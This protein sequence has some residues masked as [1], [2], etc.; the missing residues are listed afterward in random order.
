M[1]KYLSLLFFSFCPLVILSFSQEKNLQS[2]HQEAEQA[3]KDKEYEK[4]KKAYEKLLKEVR[5]FSSLQSDKYPIDWT[6]Y[7][8]CILR[9]SYIYQVEEDYEKWESMI[10][11]LIEKGPPKHQLAQLK[12]SLARLKCVQNDPQT[13]FILM[14]EALLLLPSKEWSKEN[15]SF[16]LGLTSMLDS[17]Y[18]SLVKQGE[19]YFASGLIDLAL[20]LYRE[21]LDGIERG[22][23][24]KSTPIL[25]KQLKYRVAEGN[26]LQADYDQTLSIIEKLRSE[27]QTDSID[28]EALYLRALVYRERQEFEKATLA[29]TEYLNG[30][31]K[32]LHYREALLELGLLSYREQNFTKAKKYL[33]LVAAGADSIE[34]KEVIVSSLYLARIYLKEKQY[35][36]ADR[37]LSTLLNTLP[38]GHSLIYEI[39]YLIGLVL[40]EGSEYLDA[41]T[42]FEL[43]LP[44]K[45]LD[46]EGYVAPWTPDALYQLGWCYLKLADDPLKGVSVQGA[47]ISKAESLFEILKE[48]SKKEE[49]HLACAKLFLLKISYLADQKA[50]EDLVALLTPHLKTFTQDGQVQALLLLAEGADTYSEKEIFYGQATQDTY[51]TSSNYADA[52]YQRGL[53]H[54]QE[55]L[56]VK[57]SSYFKEAAI[58][59]EKSFFLFEA[60]NCSMA[61]QILKLEAEA[62]YFLDTRESRFDSLSILEKLLH[63]YNQLYLSLEDQAHTLYLRGLVASKITTLDH[64][65]D[66]LSLAEESLKGVISFFPE[67]EYAE[68]SLF[69]LATLYF[70]LGK[71]EEAYSHFLTLATS[72]PK[73][74]HAP[75]AWFWVAHTAKQL[76]KPRVESLTALENIYMLYPTSDLAAEAYFERY[77][78]SAYEA[79]DKHSMMHLL[80]FPNRFQKSPLLIPVHYLLGLYHK[81]RNEPNLAKI[82]FG[83]SAVLYNEMEGELPPY[84]FEFRIRSLLETAKFYLNEGKFQGIE[85]LCFLIEELET[86]GE[87]SSIFQDCSLAL[88]EG[89]IILEKIPLAEKALHVTLNHFEESKIR[90]GYFL[91]KTFECGA[92]LSSFYENYEAEIDYLNLAEEAGNSHLPQEELLRLYL[93][94]AKCLEKLGKYSEAMRTLSKLI[95]VDALSPLGAQAMYHRAHLYE[96]EGR[97]ELTVRQLEACAKKGG[98]W[99]E[100]AKE[101]LRRQYG[102]HPSRSWIHYE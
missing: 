32:V 100:K 55:G 85:L 69:T 7:V 44:C 48:S 56:K 75:S 71:W 13:G 38:K 47:F 50:R 62:N 96:L 49:A 52:W 58:A 94:Q 68:G 46:L 82:S 26:F 95:N 19:V 35:R 43:A 101:L 3:I 42:H 6:T 31:E 54:F 41:A 27:N 8:D 89:L 22:V 76:G 102:M 23:Y 36:K 9:L 61:A 18:E 2:L 81:K 30:K 73:S 64:R 90:R 60:K 98:E 74:D 12:L 80:D 51:V 57:K 34:T 67:T 4:A 33:S 63:R 91:A 99:G 86:F 11:A 45:S 39:H 79:C 78:I 87:F 83:K 72:Y 40:Q 1:K 59:F 5:H 37:L 20:P 66:Y 65:E 28:H 16:F 70:H 97:E 17:H 10:L 29:L 77:P 88:I 84:C 92:E 93:K 14:Q 53:I 15:R 21:V 24:P 25:E